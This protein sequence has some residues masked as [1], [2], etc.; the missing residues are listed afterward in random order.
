MT[1]TEFNPDLIPA[2]QP[3]DA[4]LLQT[5]KQAKWCGNCLNCL[6]AYIMLTPTLT[7][8]QLVE[9]FGSDLLENTNLAPLLDELAGLSLNPNPNY[10]R[11]AR[12]SKALQKIQKERD[13]KALMKHYINESIRKWE[14]DLFEDYFNMSM[15]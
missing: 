3:I 10:P 15:T 2:D 11:I 14:G 4:S 8:E 7:D 1:C 13:H 5:I 12:V 9:I 6:Y